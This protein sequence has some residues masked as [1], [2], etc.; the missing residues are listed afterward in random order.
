MR[1]L[2]VLALVFLAACASGP[3]LGELEDQAMLSG[4]WAEVEKRERSLARRQ[5]QRGLQCPTGYL[6]YCEDRYG[7]RSCSCVQ[8]EGFR[9]VVQQR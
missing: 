9:I 2:S 3:T 6:S 4:N 5:A 7:D 8:R 1:F